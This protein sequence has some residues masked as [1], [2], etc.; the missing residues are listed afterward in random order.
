L[1]SKLLFG[2]TVVAA[3]ILFGIG[4][5]IQ[6][7][8]AVLFY[9]G[10][11]L[12]GVVMSAYLLIPYSLVPDLV[13]YYEH[14][15][16]ERHE[17]VFFGL[18]IT[19]HQLGISVAGLVLGLFLQLYGYNGNQAVQ[20]ASALMAVRLALGLLPGVFIVLASLSVQPYAIT[21][22]V[23]QQLQAELDR[24]HLTSTHD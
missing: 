1:T 4:L 12:L 19:V 20:S 10:C 6:A 9:L 14:K 2:A 8:Q 13:D 24:S 3:L 7:E 15:T 17:S 16:G 5:L 11:A 23:Y 22:Q 18:W 21:R